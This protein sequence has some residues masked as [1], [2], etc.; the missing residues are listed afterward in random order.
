MFIGLQ[1]NGVRHTV[2]SLSFTIYSFFCTFHCCLSAFAFWIVFYIH[3]PVYWFFLQ[4]CLVCYQTI[5]LI[6]L[7]LFNSKISIW[8]LAFFSSLT[9]IYWKLSSR[10]VLFFKSE[11]DN[12]NIWI[13]HESAPLSVS[14]SFTCYMLLIFN[15]CLE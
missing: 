4:L 14:S 7:I 10:V 2:F 15:F 6:S 8:F 13:L 5:F 9:F 11:S 1:W 3:F 12:S